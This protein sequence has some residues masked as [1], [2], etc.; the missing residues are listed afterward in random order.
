MSRF[1]SQGRL[2]FAVESGSAD[3]RPLE[4]GNRGRFRRAIVLVIAVAAVFALLAWQRGGDNDGS[5]PLN[6]IA[7]A[8]ERTQGEPGGRAA[9]R[10]IISSPV[11]SESFTITGDM[12]YSGERTRGAM[13]F[14]NP[15]S[16][17]S[18]EMDLVGDGLELYMRSSLFGSLPDGREWMG[19]DLSVIPT[20]DT[21]LPA[22]LDA[23]GELAIL[24]A[25]TGDVQ[26]LGEEEVRGVPTVRYRGEIDN[27]ARAEQLREEGAGK[28]ASQIEAGSPLRVEAWIDG[29]GLV[30]RMRLVRSNP[31]AEGDGSSTTDMRVDFFDFGIEPKIDV[32]EPNEVF[33]MTSIAR[34][35]LGLSD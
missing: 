26:K 33:D 31:R 19:L 7:A 34:R 27:A 23:K 17:E 12:V 6:A 14:V 32:P 5:G 20:G 10:T 4:S 25:A 16:G 18:E 29:D 3:N 8:A 15:E 28:L 9:M 1:S 21:P 11:E 30:R 22:N 2:R 13:T 24:E 35:E